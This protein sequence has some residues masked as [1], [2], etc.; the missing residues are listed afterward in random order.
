MQPVY[1]EME[2]ERDFERVQRIN[3]RN[4]RLRSLRVLNYLQL[5]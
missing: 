5:A 2:G 4:A 1:F 3:H